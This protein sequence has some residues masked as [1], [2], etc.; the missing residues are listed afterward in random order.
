MQIINSIKEIFDRHAQFCVS[1]DSQWTIIETTENADLKKLKIN[2][3]NHNFGILVNP[4]YKGLAAITNVRSSFLKDSDCDG[5]A[6]YDDGQKKRLIFVDLKSSLSSNNIKKAVKQNFF[7][8]LKLQMML[9]ICKDYDLSQYE[10]HFYIACCN[11]NDDALDSIKD[12]ILMHEEIGDLDYSTHCLRSFLFNGNNW[13][14]TI[15]ELPFINE[16]LRDDIL[17]KQ[18]HFKILTTQNPDD[19][20]LICQL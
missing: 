17:I 16:N 13:V 9:S 12:N 18:V 8:F 5:V 1:D 19:T 20:E 14:C 7:T 6:F 2:A 4:F 10:L 11:C 3:S 15:R